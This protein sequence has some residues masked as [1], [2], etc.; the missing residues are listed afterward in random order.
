MS[1][2][3]TAERGSVLG[4]RFVILCLRVFGLRAARFVAE[5]PVLYYFLSSPRARRASRTYL[6]RVAA[7]PEGRQSLGGE[8]GWWTSW[9]HFRA[10]GH[11][12]VDR[13]ACWAG[14][15]SRL[16]VVF[17]RRGELLALQE[18]KRGAILLG[19]HRGSID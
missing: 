2:N 18:Q 11:G 12:L 7:T 16:N 15:G 9:M 3:R 1:W 13:A 14:L 4:M 17:P 8:P 5:F 10:F 19:A 6:R